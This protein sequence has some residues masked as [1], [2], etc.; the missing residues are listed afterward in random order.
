MAYKSPGVYVKEIDTGTATTLP[1]G[2]RVAAIVGTGTSTRKVENIAVTRGTTLHGDDVITGTGTGDVSSIIGVGSI[3]GYY[4]YDENVDFVLSDNSISWASISGTEPAANAI[5]YVS[6]NRNKSGDD[7]AATLF[8]NI[9]DVRN[10]YGDELSAGVLNPI[11]LGAYMAFKNGAT[12]V[13]CVQAESAGAAN[14]QAAVDKLE[15][16][17]VYVVCNVNADTDSLQTYMLNHCQQQSAETMRHER[18]T[19]L[20][21]P[22]ITFTAQS[23][24]AR[25]GAINSDRVILISPPKINVALVDGTCD[26]D[27][28]LTVSGHYAACAIAGLMTNPAYDESEPLTRKPLSAIEDLAG[29]RYLETEKNTLGG[30]GVLVI[31]ND[32]GIFRIRHAITTNT[33]SANVSSISVVMIRDWFKKNLRTTLERTYIGAKILTGTITAI[34]NT[35]KAFCENQIESEILV[36]YRGIRVW[37]NTGEPRTINVT[38]DI[39]PVYPLEWIN[40]T[41]SIYV[42]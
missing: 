16:V 19:V 10:A 13:Y 30:G 2:S 37:Q 35:I 15:A 28:T 31:D 39:S 20:G 33:T 40:V 18:V 9:N 22:G 34:S 6:Y 23:L 29:T 3:P 14:I 25:A 24:A 4:D 11:T 26:A 41:F 8:Y 27:Q 1:A 42:A 38:L 36:G 7:Y 12:A 32:G 21:P 5:Y 17:D